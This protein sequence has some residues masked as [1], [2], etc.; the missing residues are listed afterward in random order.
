[1]KKI[2]EVDIEIGVERKNEKIYFSS[3]TLGRQLLPLS[4]SVALYA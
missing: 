3:F 1:M 4:L 2:I